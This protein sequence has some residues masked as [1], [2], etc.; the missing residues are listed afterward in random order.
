[1]VTDVLQLIVPDD[2]PWNPWKGLG[3]EHVQ[4][5]PREFAS[6]TLLFSQEHASLSKAFGSTGYV[7]MD[8][9]GTLDGTAVLPNILSNFLGL[10]PLPIQSLPIPNDDDWMGPGVNPKKATFQTFWGL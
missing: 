1:M 9:V 3:F 5:E 4:H 2:R 10:A 8:A 7:D 6:T